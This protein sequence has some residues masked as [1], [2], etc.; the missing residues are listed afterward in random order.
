MFRRSF[1]F[2]GAAFSASI[3]R[4]TGI[5][6]RDASFEDERWLEAEMD[7]ATKAKTPEE[8]YAAEQQRRL[9]A[10][11]MDKMRNDHKEHVETVRKEDKAHHQ[12]EVEALKAQ[13][14]EL[15]A[16]LKSVEGK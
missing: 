3:P 11:M 4:L 15:Q 14:A 13:M 2:A 9:L 1:T 8:R 16:K 7:A 12:K 6:N 10:K 5:K